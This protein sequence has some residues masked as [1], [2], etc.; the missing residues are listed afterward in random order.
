MRWTEVVAR[1]GIS[2]LLLP[3]LLISS[4]LSFPSN[5]RCGAEL[6][7]THSLFSLAGHTHT[8]S[9]AGTTSDGDPGPGHP[10]AGEPGHEHGDLVTDVAALPAELDL[11]AAALLVDDLAQ[12]TGDATSVA[13]ALDGAGHAPGTPAESG[14]QVQ[15]Q[16]QAPGSAPVAPG[17]GLPVAVTTVSATA[18]ASD[19]RVAA[20]QTLA[21]RDTLPDTPPP[22]FISPA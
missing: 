18:H 22:Q 20:E 4:L 8:A 7:H 11:G 9:G 5:C 13:T 12:P 21:G 3:A 17:V 10:H 1:I 6:P 2:S 16:V 14:E 15:V 19:L